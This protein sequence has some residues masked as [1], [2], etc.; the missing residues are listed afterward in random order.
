MPERNAKPAEN[1]MLE[2]AFEGRK[3]L[4]RSRH[5]ELLVFELLTLLER[6]NILDEDAMSSEEF[7]KIRVLYKAL[8]HGRR[9][10]GSRYS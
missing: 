2:D 7:E 8:V 9:P 3:L 1:L 6:H 4:S 10:D 5:L